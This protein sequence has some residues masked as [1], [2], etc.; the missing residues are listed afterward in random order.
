MP[1]G[2]RDDLNLQEAFE[3]ARATIQTLVAINGGAAAAIIAFYGQALTGKVSPTI[4]YYLASSLTSFSIGVGLA[5]L[6]LFFGY[7]AQ[8]GWGTNRPTERNAKIAE[9]VAVYFQWIAVGL[10]IGSLTAFGDG[11]WSARSALLH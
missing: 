2:D 8:L 9:T 1:T 6:T 11:C 5:T 4:R 7:F 3:Y 10:A